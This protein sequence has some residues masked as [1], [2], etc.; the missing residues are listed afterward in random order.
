MGAFDDVRNFNARLRGMAM[1]LGPDSQALP[2]SQPQ[3]QDATQTQQRVVGRS[4]NNISFDG[5]TGL[6][7]NYA[8]ALNDIVKFYQS[9]F[10]LTPNAKISNTSTEKSAPLGI[11][12]YYGLDKNGN[13]RVG[14]RNLTAADEATASES[15]L[16]DSNRGYSAKNPGSIAQVP[17][18]ELGHVITDM[19]FPYQKDTSSNSENRNDDYSL[20]S[21][22]NLYMDSLK[23]VGVDLTANTSAEK[24]AKKEK[25]LEKVNEISGYA[26]AQ[27][28][29]KFRLKSNNEMALSDPDQYEVIAEALSDY[30]FNRDKAAPLSKAIV[31]RLKTKGTTYGLKRS[32]GFDL[33]T[34]SDNFIKNL[35]RYNAIQ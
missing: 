27:G 4:G 23:D 20:N 30:Y 17:V 18:H 35:R 19:L 24:T 5:N 25:A 3:L 33:N 28:K 34:N 16:E 26:A 14:L 13:R 12:Y 10:K 9:E 29:Q 1:G 11:T 8:N 15:A 32:G 31:K 22:R 2:N 6:S 7:D 21:L